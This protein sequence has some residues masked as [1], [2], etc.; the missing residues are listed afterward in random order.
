LQDTTAKVLFPITNHQFPIPLLSLAPC[1]LYKYICSQESPSSTMVT[2][3][4]LIIFLILLN[5]FFV[6][7]EFAIVKVRSSQIDMKINKGSARAK[8]VKHILS[9]MDAYLSATQLGIT[10]ASLILGRV[11]EP[12]VSSLL[13]KIF[14]HFQISISQSAL[15]NI[16]FATGIALI[17]V[18]HMV[19]GEQVPKTLSIRYS[20]QTSMLVSFPLRVFY[21]VFAPFIWMV[22]IFTRITLR[23]FGVKISADHEDIHSEE[24]LRLL[25]TESEEGGAIKQSEHELIQNVFEFDD[26]A[27]RSIL[28][29]RTKISAIDIEL[30]PKVILDKMIEEGYSRMPVYK[31]SLDNI[32][33]IIYAKDLLKLLMLGKMGRP[34]IESMIRPAHF[35]P[36]NKRINEL[37]RE[38][39]TLHIQ[40]AIVTNEFGGIQGLVTMED[41]IEELVGEIQDEY[42][43]EK[44]AVEKKSETEF[45]VNAMASIPDVNDVLPI[46]LP[47]SPHYESISGLMNYLFGRI[48]AVNEKKQ[49]GGYE[50]L[51]VKR[52]KHSV[53]SVK[54]TVLDEGQFNEE[55]KN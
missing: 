27:V 14:S 23:L 32:I 6:A 35:I 25:L 46:A 11:G 28:V 45:I 13:L 7:A 15:N 33:G 49:F 3:L 22:N 43:E 40:M 34:E 55:E 1:P 17:T 12:Y 2:D 53:E 29:P 54:M 18:I 44:P 31:D 42:D 24:E 26:R 30:D 52:F 4:L 20:L 51:I 16:A 19:I 38:F 36:Q 10:V 9:K 47:E 21:Y 39:Q 37:L 5:A 50:F 41:V 48:P 8:V